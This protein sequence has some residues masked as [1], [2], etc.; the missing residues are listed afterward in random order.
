MD[1]RVI[2]RV[3]KTVV[4]LVS[5]GSM[6]TAMALERARLGLIDEGEFSFL[7]GLEYEEGAYG[8]ADSTSLWRVP[9][10][11]SF[12]KKNIGLFASVPLLLAT[13]DGDIITSNK[14]SM[15]RS[16]TT[17]SQKRAQTVTGIGDILLSASYYLTPDYRN[18]TTY[19]MT[20]TLKL[21]TADEAKGLGTG[22]NDLFIEGG[23]LK[24]IDEYILSGTLGYEISGDSSLFLYNN[25]FYVTAGLSKRLEMNSQIGTYLY[26][27][28]SITDNSD[29]PLE[30]SVFYTQ[31]VAK[32]RSIYLFFS[33][34]FS[35]ASPDFSIGG[36]IQFYY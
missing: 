6:Q 22:E 19:R 31:P 30:L 15:R 5:L 14:T 13:S 21:G 20:A 24:N 36:T 25:V 16:D 8:T 7:T 33:K 11:I 27:S 10:N 23:F 28:Q 4:L 17:A 1:K 9:L 26:F 12:R 18:E 34:G 32:N 3:I 29:S 2:K 35:D